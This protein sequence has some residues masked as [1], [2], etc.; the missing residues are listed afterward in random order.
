MIR[1]RGGSLQ[2][3][4]FAGRDPLTGRKRW[5]SRQVRGQTKAA[6][7]E[8]KKVEAQLLE[9]LDR[10]EQRG[11]RTRTVGELVERW[12]EWRQQVRPISPV[13][14]ANHRGAIDRYI[15]PNRKC[16]H[17]WTRIRRGEPALRAVVR[18]GA[19]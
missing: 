1:K 8:A 3:Q 10:G 2:V 4:V 19:T 16:R 9:Q 13:T 7:R 11:S 17:C 18:S 14:V 15:L 6:W 12:L 5:L